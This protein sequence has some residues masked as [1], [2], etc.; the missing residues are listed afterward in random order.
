[1]NP[2][3]LQWVIDTS[4]FTHIARAGH[5]EILELLAPTGVLVVPD[6][7]SFEVDAGRHGYQ[8]IP[9][10]KDLAWVE[11]AVL[12]GPEQDTQLHAKANLATAGTS[13][14]G[15]CAVIAVAK[16]RGMLAVLD[17]AKG[18]AE[19]AG[20]GVEV[21]MT[22]WVVLQAHLHLPG[23][24][25]E[26]TVNVVNEL[27]ATGMHLGITSGE[28]FFAEAYEKGWLPDDVVRPGCTCPRCEE[29]RATVGPQYR[30]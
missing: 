22:L 30:A 13:D 8:G 21:R 7:V 2:W 1:M 20:H 3:G 11:L 28:S 9:D 29:V 4:G 23:Y 24:D 18:R 6:S 26:K 17:D 25:R 5:L 14:L 16:H 10:I 15:E 12:L 19:A 27:L